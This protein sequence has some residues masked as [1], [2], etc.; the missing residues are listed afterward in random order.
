MITFLSGFVSGALSDGY[1]SDLQSN[2]E[3]KISSN[4]NGL[5]IHSNQLSLIFTG[6]TI[7]LL[8]RTYNLI[9]QLPNNPFLE[10]LSSNFLGYGLKIN[11]NQLTFILSESTINLSSSAVISDGLLKTNPF[12]EQ[13]SSTILEN[14]GHKL[15]NITNLGVVGFVLLDKT[16]Y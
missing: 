2:Q 8:T 13:M 10:Q 1:N 15:S 12:P 6:S 5:D 14:D 16:R 4:Q 9:S 11:T 3:F 7:N